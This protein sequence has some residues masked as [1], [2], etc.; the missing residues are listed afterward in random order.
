MGIHQIL[1][2]AAAGDAITTLALR[3]R[4][5]LR[6]HGD[7]EVFA[8]YRE[9]E[10]IDDVH[11]LEEYSRRYP[12]PQQL[13]VFHASI[14]DPRVHEFLGTRT[15]PILLVYHNVAPPLPYEP[16]D[17]VLAERLRAGRLQLAGLRDRVAGAVADSEFNAAELRALGFDTVHVARPVGGLT[18]LRD[19]IPPAA[20]TYHLETVH[21]GPLLLFV[22]QVLPHKALEQLLLAFHVLVTYLH[23]DATLVIAGPLRSQP[24]TSSL[25]WLV[26]S[27]RIPSVVLSGRVSDETLAAFYRRADLFVTLSVHEGF[28]I[29]VVEAMAFDVPVLATAVAALPETVGD[30]GLLLPPAP[31]PTLV[32][33]AASRLL[34]DCSLRHELIE[35]GRRRVAGHA[36][37]GG[38]HDFVD[39]ALAAAR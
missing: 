29:P 34:T 27:L 2:G 26:R 10:I 5:A 18:A 12:A 33:E 17:P 16:F 3:H 28:C 22:G 6:R 24:Y 25:R 30:A 13:L 36:A 23:L 35:H 37:V 8:L 19:V 32:A 38:E 7:S 14:G 4:D 31:E 39:I 9:P 15:E 11:T 1:V 20:M 21:R